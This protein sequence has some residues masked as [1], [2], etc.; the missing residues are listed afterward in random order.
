M[1]VSLGLFCNRTGYIVYLLSHCEMLSY[2]EYLNSCWGG[3][4]S[5]GTPTLFLDIWISHHIHNLNM[6]LMVI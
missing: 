6:L 1:R 3:D 5:I 2:T 4:F